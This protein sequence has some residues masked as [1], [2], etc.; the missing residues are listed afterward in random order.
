MPRDADD[1]DQLGREIQWA[2]DADVHFT[3]TATLKHRFEYAEGT[4]RHVPVLD[5]EIRES[6]ADDPLRTSFA[7]SW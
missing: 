4:S 1:T 2:G 5:P 6:G 7:R 3:H